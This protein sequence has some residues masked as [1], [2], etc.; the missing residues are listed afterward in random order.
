MQN[1]GI[2]ALAIQYG[3]FAEVGMAAKHVDGLLS[4]GMHPL[5]PREVQH[6]HIYDVY[7]C[8]ALHQNCIS[9]KAFRWL[10]MK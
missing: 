3:P 9:I 7:A 8:S 1:H 10:L 4:V 2:H 5:R 6:S